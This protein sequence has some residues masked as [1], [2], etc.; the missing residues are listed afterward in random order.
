MAR[1]MS[2]LAFNSQPSCFATAKIIEVMRTEAAHAAKW[3]LISLAYH[4]PC[5]NVAVL[6]AG[7]TNRWISIPNLQGRITFFA[8]L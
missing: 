2:A 4:V 5:L 3:H 8:H 6:F 7:S 1:H